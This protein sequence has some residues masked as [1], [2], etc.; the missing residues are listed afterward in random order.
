MELLHHP[1][2]TPEFKEVSGIENVIGYRNLKVSLSSY[3]TVRINLI[4][5]E[6][7]NSSREYVLYWDS[8][9]RFGLSISSGF[10]PSARR[11]DDNEATFS[12]LH[13]M[14]NGM[15]ISPMC[16]DAGFRKSGQ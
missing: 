7:A 8:R 4:Q 11:K 15:L 6:N 16:I 5:I 10:R 14:D 12:M 2:Y 1:P 13:I 9:S 3:S